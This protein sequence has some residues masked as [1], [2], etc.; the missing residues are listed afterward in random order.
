MRAKA[1]RRAVYEWQFSMDGGKTWV[2]AGVT[3]EA[4]V[5]ISGLTLGTTYLFRFRTTLKRVTADFC[6]P[7]S[8]LVH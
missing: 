6:Q 8:L 1:T 7:Y 5:T 2:S 3:S 4:N